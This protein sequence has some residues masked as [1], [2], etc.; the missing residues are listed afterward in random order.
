MHIKIDTQ[1]NYELEAD[2]RTSSKRV[3][4][5]QHRGIPGDQ[6]DGNPVVAAQEE[7]APSLVNYLTSCA[8]RE[9]HPLPGGSDRKKHSL[10]SPSRGRYGIDKGSVRVIH[11]VT[12]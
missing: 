4:G 7:R 10:K 8:K 5:E 6:P 3:G 1:N 2:P 12:T 9:A 11:R